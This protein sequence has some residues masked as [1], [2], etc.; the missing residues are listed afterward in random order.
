M[1]ND[2]RKSST[3][4]AAL[5]LL[6][7]LA[8]HA[9]GAG[10][11][12]LATEL[13]MHKSTVHV[14]LATFAEQ[15]FVERLPDGRYR[16]GIAAF[17]VG[18][19]VSATARLGG[20]LIPPMQRLAKLTGEAVSLAVMRGVDAIIVQRFETEHVLRAEITIGTRMPL[21]SCASGKVLLASLP[22]RELS[23][24]L[25]DDLPQ[26][27]PS[28]RSTRSELLREL[29]VVRERGWSQND[30]EFVMGVSGI[31]TGVVDGGGACAAALSVAGPTAR[32]DGA[33]WVELLMQTAAEMSTLLAAR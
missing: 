1:T 17:E 18:S 31:A 9:D 15:E 21:T 8:A 32:F 19:A 10:V 22:D 25:P 6:K 12:G 3:V 24:M 28:S 2:S 11:T 13:G 16:L 27:T 7:A 30:D 20:D 29:A 33:R 23:A 5:R 26:V 4:A 14:L